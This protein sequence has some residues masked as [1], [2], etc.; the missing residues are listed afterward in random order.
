[1]YTFGKWTAKEG[2]E[3]E[4]ARRWQES[5]DKLVLEFPDITF[6]LLRSTEDPRRFLSTGGPWKN[7]EQ[8]EAARNL[9]SFQQAM[10]DIQALLE[11]GGISTYELVA[12][13]S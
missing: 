9:P 5:V 1:M 7:A 8:I 3:E 4:F 12:E 11:E 6:R 2:R 10:S 13:V